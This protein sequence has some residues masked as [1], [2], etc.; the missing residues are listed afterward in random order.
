MQLDTNK[1]RHVS[2]SDV[3]SDADSQP[4][5]TKQ[6]PLDSDENH[7]LLV[8]LQ[9]WLQKERD[10]Q[11]P[12]R[13]DMA[14][15]RDYYDNI[16]WTQE[17]IEALKERGQRAAVINQVAPAVDWVLGTE[18][19]LKVDWRI[20][21][22]GPEDGAGADALSKLTKYVSD[23]NKAPHIRS[24]AFE[25]A[26]I[27]GIGWIEV[28]ATSDEDKD[29]I[30]VKVE[31][32]RNIYVD[33]AS[34][35]ND[36]SDARYLF[37]I[38]SLDT[39]IAKVLFP[40]RA[41]VIEIHK[42]DITNTSLSQQYYEEG[43]DV[44]VTVM[45]LSS[46]H[47][48]NRNVVRLVEAWFKVPEAVKVIRG[49]RLSGTIY[50]QD[51]TAHAEAVQSGGASIRD[52]VRM[53]VY[54]AIFIDQ[55]QLLY[56]SKSPYKHERF[57]FIPVFGKK[58]GRDNQT[59]GMVRSMRDPQDGLNKRRSKAD[60]MLASNRI[61]MEKGAVDDEDHAR[62]EAARPDGVIVLNGQGKRF[63]ISNN[64]QMAEAH[65]QIE[66]NDSAY[67]RTAS[68]VTGE[69][70]G[71]N[72]NATSGK[73]ILARQDQ[74]NTLLTG[75]FDNLR[76]AWQV[77]GEMILSL[78]KQVY[79]EEQIIRIGID[80]KSSNPEWLAINKWDHESGS[81]LNDIS[82]TMADFVVTEQDYRDSMRQAMYEQMLDMAGKLPPEVALKMLDLILEFADL[83]DKEAIKERLQSIINPPPPPPQQ[84]DPLVEAKIKESLANANLKDANA[85]QIKVTAL[86]SAI[87][88]AQQLAATPQLA[89]MVDDMTQ[90]LDN[91]LFPNQ[92]APAQENAGVQPQPQEVPQ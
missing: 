1:T 49:G 14:T 27:S 83:P 60:W 75:Y 7:T 40:E 24:K 52:S 34:R 64:L 78:I 80:P 47:D 39:D 46:T 55:G 66:N 56:V 54:C 77:A 53:C 18:K 70:L 38:K 69:N 9:G 82:Q 6:N 87:T 19:K 88:G 30:Q 36:I 84:M 20:L 23:T 65:V 43:I 5:E 81:Y 16:Q 29:P 59:Y 50:E 63:E 90:N 86:T 73:A 15:E 91:I 10:L 92:P 22:R 51:N 4:E 44:P 76:Y 42:H 57:P 67:I 72:T 25:D 17:E 3:Y 35:E 85:Q 68:G 45:G 8:R 28:F 74:G 11:H 58:R 12:N 31:N 2:A 21:P 71:L 62:E 33:S 13:I 26:V 61:I 32:W 89:G 37:R 79:T 48:T 41:D